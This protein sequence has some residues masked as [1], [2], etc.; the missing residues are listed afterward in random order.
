[1]LRNYVVLADMFHSVQFLLWREAD[2]SLNLVSKDYDHCTALSTAFLNDG[3]KLG[4]LMGDDEGN[5]QML[6]QNPR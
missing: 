4:V 5:V 3:A 2:L 1:M 6:Q